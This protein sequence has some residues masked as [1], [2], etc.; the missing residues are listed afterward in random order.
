M[1]VQYAFAI[2]RVVNASCLIEYEPEHDKTNKMA[3]A[4]S[5]DSDKPIHSASL[6]SLD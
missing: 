2:L 3:C 4:T 5:R 6:F 1:P